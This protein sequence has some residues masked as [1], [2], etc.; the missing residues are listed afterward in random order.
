MALTGR[1][2]YRTMQFLGIAAMPT[3]EEY[4]RSLWAIVRKHAAADPAAAIS[5]DHLLEWCIAAFTAPPPAFDPAWLGLGDIEWPAEIGM[6]QWEHIILRQVADLRRMAEAGTLDQPG[7]YFGV[8]APSG[9]SWYN[10]H[11]LSY[12]EAAVRGLCDS[13][14]LRQD[15]SLPPLTWGHMCQMLECGQMYE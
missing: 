10:F 7:L 11:P 5:P 3:L 1:D 15:D 2:L 4:L 13:H 9:G 12:L 14:R 8:E 6:A